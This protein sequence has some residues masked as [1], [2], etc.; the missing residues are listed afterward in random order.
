MFLAVAGV[1]EYDPALKTKGNYKSY[2]V[3]DN[4]KPKNALSQ[5]EFY[6]GNENISKL[7]LRLFRLK[8]MKDIMLRPLI[9]EA[10]IGAIM[11]AIMLTTITLCDSV[12]DICLNRLIHNSCDRYTVMKIILDRCV[13]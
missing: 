8:F 2:L 12:S 6:Q 7:S 10:G 3:S 5:Q 9:D 11:N 1:W 4:A 13:V